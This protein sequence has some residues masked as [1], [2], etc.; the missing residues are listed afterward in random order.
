MQARPRRRGK[1]AMKLPGAGAA[2]RLPTV[3]SKPLLGGRDARP[4]L[5]LL[6][7]HV[8]GPLDAAERGQDLELVER[9]QAPDPEHFALQPGEPG[10]E[11]EVEMG[12]REPEELICV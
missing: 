3:L 2:G 4:E 11:R 12:L 6:A 9:A 7:R 8:Q 1:G 10:A 5:D